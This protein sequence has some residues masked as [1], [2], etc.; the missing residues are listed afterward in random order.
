M[1]RRLKRDSS[2]DVSEMLNELS[3]DED[4]QPVDEKDVKSEIKNAQNDKEG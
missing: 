1:L 2:R 4:A 3:I